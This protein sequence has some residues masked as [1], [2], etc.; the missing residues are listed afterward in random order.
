MRQLGKADLLC[1]VE[2]DFNLREREFRRS[3]RCMEILKDDSTIIGPI[4]P[5]NSANSRSTPSHESREDSYREY[6]VFNKTAYSDYVE[7]NRDDG[8]AK[9]GSDRER[10][11]LVIRLV[12]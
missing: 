2:L 11:I 4:Q 1:V 12:V 9:F 6:E 8:S 10:S 3:K 7:L 5:G